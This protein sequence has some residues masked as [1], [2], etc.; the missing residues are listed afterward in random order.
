MP[1]PE[2]CA[3]ACR[4]VDD[5]IHRG[6]SLD[7]TTTKR[8]SALPKTI[9]A[10]TKE[11]SWGAIRWYYR[12]QFVIKELLYR[13]IKQKDKILESLILCGLYQLDYLDEPDYAITSNTVEA[14]RL[15]NKKYACG[16][17]NA[18]LRKYLK[19]H[20]DVNNCDHP[21]WHSM[22]DW[23]IDSLRTHWPDH[24]RSI[25]LACNQ[26][27]PLTLMINNRQCDKLTYL[28]RLKAL[29]L[30]AVE[31]TIS[32]S[33][34]TLTKS[35]PVDEIPGFTEGDVSVQDA[36][37]Q[38]VPLFAGKLNGKSVLD[39]CAAPGGKTCHLL[40]L[41]NT[42][43]SITALDL[44]DRINQIE[45]NLT[46]LKLNAK[47]IAGDATHPEQWWDRNP[48]DCIIVDAP[49]S[50]TG[51]IRR[52]PDVRIHRKK[53]DISKFADHQI[54]LLTSLWP[55]LS[56]GGRMIYITCSILPCN[57]AHITD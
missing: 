11:I 3:T 16:L 35:V 55:L 56:P 37:A 48:F 51:V 20:K 50:A 25:A 33:A 2:V 26:K 8:L 5:V 52:H 10:E 43:T 41:A 30:Q 47:V 28:S 54:D 27:P 38:L 31:S 45:D 9:R 42:D 17:V 21:L 32:Q 29:G 13:P 53:T 57:Y 1:S 40:E 18:V 39:A 34:I 19:C 22:P 7:R 36:A 6:R 15:L 49:C 4:I 46:R 12:Y 23:L 44:P 24:W 14:C